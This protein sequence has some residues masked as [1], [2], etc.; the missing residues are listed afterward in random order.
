MGTMYRDITTGHDKQPITV[1]AFNKLVKCGVAWLG[2]Y[3]AVLKTYPKSAHQWFFKLET[4]MKR[5]VS[6]VKGF[7]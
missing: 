4:E 3:I 5:S 7:Y 6:V 2:G 1:W